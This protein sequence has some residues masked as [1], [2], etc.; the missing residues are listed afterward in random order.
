MNGIF[1]YIMNPDNLINLTKALYRVTDSLPDNEPLKYSLRAK[2]IKILSEFIGIF[3]ENSAYQDSLKREK[4]ISSLIKDIRIVRIYF[5]VAERQSWV[6]PENFLVLGKEYLKMENKIKE[7]L[8]KDNRKTII[9][10]EKK[11]K[12]NIQLSDL[13]A[14]KE[15]SLTGKNKKNEEKIEVRA[16]SGEEI[17]KAKNERQKKI[18]EILRKKESIQVKDLKKLFPSI[19]KRT[20]R[21]DFVYLLQE[22]IVYR[23]G[24]K[25][26]TVYKINSGR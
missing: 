14:E 10:E 1:Y 22:G 18:L 9:K 3:L 7:S 4:E 12:E 6:R 5:E 19:S 26:E 21:R 25:N 8:G 24:K 15:S 20:I 2:S 11:E 23:E 13:L 16:E 17:N